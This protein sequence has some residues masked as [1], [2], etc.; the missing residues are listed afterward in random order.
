M[1]RKDNRENRAAV[2]ADAGQEY[3]LRLF[4]AGDEPNSN[5]AKKN[6]EQICRAH[7]SGRC[8]IDIIDVLTDFQTALE[9][10]VVVTPTLISVSP[11]P[12][13]TV[14]GTLANTQKVLA[15][16]RLTEGD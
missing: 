11:P 3:H 15:A 14:V 4:V 16:L 8:R 13:A 6:L 2:A 1:K 10:G 12:R 9:S 7:C 5:R